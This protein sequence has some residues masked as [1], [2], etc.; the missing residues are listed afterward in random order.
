MGMVMLAGVVGASP[1]A[2]GALVEIETVLEM[3]VGLE[4]P[5]ARGA[6]VEI[7]TAIVP[8]LRLS[9]APRKGGVG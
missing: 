4:S 5:P 1:P 6:L 7:R 9:V 8:K 3:A 2:R